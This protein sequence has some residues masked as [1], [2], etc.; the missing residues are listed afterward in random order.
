M[1]L[2]SSLLHY[3]LEKTWKEAAEGLP[4]V[5]NDKIKALKESEINRREDLKERNS[6]LFSQVSEPLP[7]ERQ[8]AL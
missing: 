3:L 4:L 7:D 5:K 2:F 8:R 6:P 1:S